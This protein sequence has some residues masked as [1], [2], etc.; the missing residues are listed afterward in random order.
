MPQV[1]TFKEKYAQIRKSCASATET[2]DITALERLE[3]ECLDPEKDEIAKQGGWGIESLIY[4]SLAVALRR[5]IDFWE[6][7]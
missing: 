1:Q 2:V 6:G 5:E 3:R 4:G 7:N